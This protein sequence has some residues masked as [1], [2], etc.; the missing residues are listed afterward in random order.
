[1]ILHLYINFTVE[2][3]ISFHI[4]AVIIDHMIGW[5]ISEIYDIGRSSIAISGLFKYELKC[6]INFGAYFMIPNCNDG[7]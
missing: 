3:F 5:V 4:T 1:M 6:P 2:W 7:R